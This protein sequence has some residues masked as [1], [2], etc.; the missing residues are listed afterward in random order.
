MTIT[1]RLYKYPLPKFIM[2]LSTYTMYVQEARNIVCSDRSLRWRKVAAQQIEIAQL[3]SLMVINTEY[4]ST[5][6]AVLGVS[7]NSTS[8]PL[9]DFRAV[10]TFQPVLHL[11][12]SYI[13]ILEKS[14]KIMSVSSSFGGVI[15]TT[16]QYI[17]EQ[18][19]KGNSSLYLPNFRKYILIAVSMS[20]CSCGP[21]HHRRN[22]RVVNLVTLASSR[23]SC[24]ILVCSI[25]FLPSN[26]LKS[27]YEL[28][29]IS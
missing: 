18:K 3:K 17:L 7:P 27:N 12:A 28:L 9:C 6:F 23:S 19:G 24:S 11:S 4:V 16:D 15:G 21:S 1:R 20:C 5:Y 8:H 26:P 13:K 14:Y 10:V 25:L 2:R 29:S 22:C